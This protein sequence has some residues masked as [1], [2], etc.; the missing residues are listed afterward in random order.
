MTLPPAT[1]SAIVTM[2]ATLG[3]WLTGWA[4]ADA[5][6]LHGDVIMLATVLAVTMSRLVAR[7]KPHSVPERLVRLVAVPLVAL[8]SSETGTLLQHHRW[9]GG[10]VFCLVMALS[11]WVRRFGRRWS[12]LGSM[13]ALPFV[14]LLVAPVAP[15]P[16]HEHTLWPALLAVVALAWVALVQQVAWLTGFVPVPARA[17][18]EPPPPPANGG[19]RASTKMAVQLGLGLAICYSL[20]TWWFPEH[21]PWMVLSCYV[22]MV[23]TAGRGD[24]LHR[25]L[26]RLVG[27]AAGTIGATLLASAF[28]TGN[29]WALVLLF[30]VMGLAVWLRPKNYAYWAAGVTSML[31]LLHGYYGDHGVHLLVERL[32]GVVLGA[33]TGVA[34]TWFVL[35]VRT[36][37]AFRRRWA[38]ALAALSDELAALRTDPAT[39]SAADER[40]R[41]A[42]AQ[43]ALLEPAYRA[44]RQTVARRLETRHPVDLLADL[45]RVGRALTAAHDDLQDGHRD[46]V[47]AWS[48][49]VGAIRRRMKGD[50]PE[51]EAPAATGNARLDSV[52]NALARLDA[53]F[54]R[55][56]W[57][58]L[59]G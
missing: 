53:D 32:A 54:E 18:D 59:G 7:Q 10:A 48:R 2:T 3:S 38:D 16:G 24:A 31:A 50:E 4:I 47:V 25:G 30:V 21:W 6:G 39:A 58:E 13:A 52:T 51:V 46:T 35:P 11:V 9:W 36:R 57:V 5:F 29:R 45:S 19:L 55:E 1:R 44:H 28:A 20:G 17:P 56:L 26:M 27:A 49:Q 22:V 37:D 12:S 15:A 23:G 41:H 43:L 42:A 33:G 40:F 34:V 14:V 8:A